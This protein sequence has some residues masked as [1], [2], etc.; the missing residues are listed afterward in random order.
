[1]SDTPDDGDEPMPV[2][3]D[4][5]TTSGGQQSSKSERGAGESASRASHWRAVTHSV[6][7]P[8]RSLRLLPQSLVRRLG[9]SYLPFPLN[10]HVRKTWG[11]GHQ[12]GALMCA[13]GQTGHRGRD[14]HMQGPKSTVGEHPAW[15]HIH[16][17]VSCLRGAAEIPG[18]MGSR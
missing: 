2:P 6:P 12:G 18:F 10:H 13:G 9:S 15:G 3:E 4:L 8:P 16:S 17:A 7:L 11:K 5:S 14:T 1:M